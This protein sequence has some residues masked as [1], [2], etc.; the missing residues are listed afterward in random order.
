M[1]TSW[2]QPHF[3][4]F[5]NS[6]LDLYALPCKEIVRILCLNTFVIIHNK[7]YLFKLTTCRQLAFSI[8]LAREREWES[9]LLLCPTLRGS[10]R[11]YT[12]SR[13]ACKGSG[14][15]NGAERVAIPPPVQSTSREACDRRMTS[16]V[17]S[18]DL[19]ARAAE[20]SSSST[21]SVTK[22]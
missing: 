12:G 8:E 14:G 5:S 3:F 19:I 9:L 4:P 6:S 10:P 16:V 18:D 15:S 17:P 21:T 2:K 13:S 1:K 11:F 22:L 7:M 20:A